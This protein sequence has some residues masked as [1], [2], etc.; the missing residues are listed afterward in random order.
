[1][2]DAKQAQMADFERSRSQ[3]LGVSSQKQQ[4]QMQLAVLKQATEELE[5]T[6]EKKVFKA[7]GNILIQSDVGVVKKE[8]IGKTESIELRMK[9]LQKQEESL[10]NKLNKLKSQIEGSTAPD[11]V[12]ETEKQSMEKKEKK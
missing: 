2:A 1:M 3:L 4:L 5:K 6:K 7:V 8:I 9:T 10:I 12:L 11:A